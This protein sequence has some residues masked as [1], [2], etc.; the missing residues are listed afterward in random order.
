MIV[1]FFYSGPLS[2]LPTMLRPLRS[3][4]AVARCHPDCPGWGHG[5]DAAT[6]VQACDLCQRFKTDEEARAA[7]DVECGACRG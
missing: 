1:L 3:L 5:P 4:P 2:K 6:P 7:H